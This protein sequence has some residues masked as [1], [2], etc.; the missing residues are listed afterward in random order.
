[1]KRLLLLTVSALALVQ[2]AGSP[3]AEQMAETGEDR[4]AAEVVLGPG[5]TLASQTSPAY[6]VGSQKIAEAASVS[7]DP[8]MTGRAAV[9]AEERA[10]D[11]VRLAAAKSSSPEPAADD[12]HAAPDG[13]GT[14]DPSAEESEEPLDPSWATVRG[15]MPFDII[16][17]IQFLQDQVARGNGRAIQVQALL[18]RRY[19]PVFVKADPSVWSDARNQRAAVL[20][21]L[22]GGPPEVLRELM[23]KGVVD[24]ALEPMFKGALAYVD[25]DLAT[26]QVSLSALDFEGVE[27]G[28]EAHINLVLGQMKQVASPKDAIPHLDRARLLAPGGLIE[29]A[30][31]RMEMLIVDELGDHV[32]ADHLA[33]QYFDRYARSSYSA[34]FEARF[35][36]VYASR[37]KHEPEAAF[38]T[39]LDVTARLADPNKRTI[40]LAV[41]RRALFEGYL[42]FAG[43]SAEAALAT[44]GIDDADRQRAVLYTIAARIGTMPEAEAKA[45]LATV[46]RAIL[47][48]EDAE[49]YD[50]A[51]SVLAGID[52]TPEVLGEDGRGEQVAESSAVFDRAQQVLNGVAS[53]LGKVQP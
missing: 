51:A 53:D 26:A 28:L 29:E 5:L 42:T 21:V 24:P 39:M 20:F 14:G 46:D 34:N 40:Y 49:L 47:H 1:M 48:A 15:P 7:L 2:A 16:R 36:S 30:A 6:G 12:G 18:L 4:F 38:A 22:S 44:Q 33:R 17:T 9:P 11:F 23:A 32:F 13:G 3:H 25:N 10:T 8:K 19:G 41:G 45:T 27:P 31:L 35:A 43:L 37:G 52:R 50:A